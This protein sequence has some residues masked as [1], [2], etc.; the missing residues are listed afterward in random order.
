MALPV[1]DTSECTGCSICCD[2][3]PVGALELV[4]GVA[5]LVRPDDCTECGL[6]IDECPMS[7]IS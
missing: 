5:A 2:G 7:A 6:C 4:D 1:I 3:C